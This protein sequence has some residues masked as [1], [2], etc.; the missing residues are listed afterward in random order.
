MQ[1]DPTVISQNPYEAPAV[2]S[3]PV[4]EPYSS[5]TLADPGMRLIAHI[6]DMIVFLGAFAVAM[7]GSS[8]LPQEKMAL[9][10]FGGIFGALVIIVINLYLL[11]ARGQSIGKVALGI[12]IVRV[13]GEKASFARIFFLRIGIPAII[14]VVPGLGSMFALVDSLMIFQDS[15]QC[16]HDMIADTKVVRIR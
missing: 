16:I 6:I 13:S 8:F 14:N 15:R 12:R 7:A 2:A 1:Q 3:L 10:I 5:G 9:G 4:E 11:A